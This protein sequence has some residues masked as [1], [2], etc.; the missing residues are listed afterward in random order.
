MRLSVII[1]V[2]DEEDNIRPLH[3]RLA[4]AV[5]AL[6]GDAEFI[7][8]DDGSAD[9]TAAEVVALRAA[10]PRV[11][12]LRLSRN[13]GHQAALTAGMDVAD[14]E[15]VISLDGDLQHPPELIGELVRR[16][17][18]G[19]EVV[20]TVRRASPDASAFKTALSVLFYRVFRALSGVDLPANA[21][22]FRLLDARVVRSLRAM[23]ER[24]RFLRGLVCW[25]GYRS[26]GVEY[27]AS[28]R[29]GGRS[30]YGAGRMLA[31]ALDALISFST[32]PL[33]AALAVGA[34][35]GLF[36][37]AYAVFALY[38]RLITHQVLPG[39]TSL[40]IIV[41]IV[42]GFQLLLLGLL[43]LYLGKVYDEVKA[44]PTYLV[45]EAVGFP[46]AR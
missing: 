25:A 18:D 21:A 46:S 20:Y 41:S 39:W 38:A 34:A 10:D 29:A 43:G 17:R 9:R 4:A 16:W 11:R 40:M 15:A 24:S 36:G 5:S 2:H 31:L 26:V 37:F 45:A 6:S 19:H 13:F 23:P 32:T 7:F 27:D 12:L 8:V 1:P 14:G 42:G 30:K 28:P 22:D 33:Y 3:G 44:R 35:V